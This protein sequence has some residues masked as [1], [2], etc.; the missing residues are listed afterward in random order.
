MIEGSS[1]EPYLKRGKTDAA[2]AE[3]FAE[4]VTR[5][6][7]RFVPVKT[8]EQQSVLMLHKTRDLL[9][10]QRTA[11]INALRGHMGELGIV[12]PQGARKVPGLVEALR[13]AAGEVPELARRALDMLVE[14]LGFI[15][16]GI[17]KAEESILAWHRA[18]AASRRLA[19]IPGVG[20]ITASAIAATVPA[21]GQ[22]GS[23]RQF[24]AWL[25]L[26]PKPRSSGGKERLGRVS[27]EGN[28]YLRRLLVTGMT[29]VLRHTRA[30]T[31]RNPWAA[32]LLERKPARLVT[33]ALANKTARVA[34]AVLARGQ[35][36]VAPAA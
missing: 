28:V 26:T 25:G 31:T 34:W 8:A 36:Y 18:N 22:F 11:L 33:V 27:R 9:V 13:A 5:P 21:A 20:P 35:T 19:T 23:G 32:K 10:R 12:A 30:D 3:A 6:T 17:R 7:M 16:I 4:A 24:A 1:C 29:A 14:Q 15:E 2:N